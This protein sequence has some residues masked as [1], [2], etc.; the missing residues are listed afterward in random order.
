MSRHAESCEKC[1]VAVESIDIG[2]QL[3]GGITNAE[4]PDEV[5]IHAVI[6]DKDTVLVVLCEAFIQIILESNGVTCVSF[7]EINGY[8]QSILINGKRYLNKRKMAFF[9]ALSLFSETR[10]QHHR[11]VKLIAYDVSFFIDQ[12]HGIIFIGILKVD[13]LS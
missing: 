8:R 10:F 12:I 9:L 6:S 7:K 3:C 2:E 1:S 11:L 13:I 5:C 4:Q